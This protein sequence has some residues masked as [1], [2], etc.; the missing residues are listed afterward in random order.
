M[1]S[2]A[3]DP[4]STSVPRFVRAVYDML[5]NEDQRILSWS[6]DG[7]HF[8]VY[9]VP[10]LEVEV[11]RKYFKHGKFT[12]FQRQ[13]NNFGFHKWAKTRAS[14]A[15]FSH[16]VLVR[17]HLSQLAA[18]VGRMQVKPTTAAAAVTQT[19]P[20]TSTSTKRPRCLLPSA[21]ELFSAAK[22]HKLSP[23][24][25]CAVDD[26][27]DLRFASILEPLWALNDICNTDEEL[28]LDALD[29]I[30]LTELAELDWDAVISPLEVYACDSD[31][32]VDID[33]AASSL[34]TED[35]VTAVLSD[36]DAVQVLPGCELDSLL[37]GDSDTDADFASDADF[38]ANINIDI[39]VALGADTLLFV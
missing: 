8:Q 12:S 20:A 38:D 37:G 21:P 36:L 23:R 6:A 18:L 33:C 22:K 39:D 27:A 26:L 19:R 34:L 13:L 28:L 15:T 16:D 14:V 2:T 11:L 32:D 30:E 35:D 24:D 31:S 3:G 25:V 9:D 29:P 10:R 1:N 17:C 4:A 7:S 5:Q